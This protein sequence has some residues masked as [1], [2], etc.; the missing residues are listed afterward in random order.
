MKIREISNYLESLAPLSTQES[1]D[2]CGLIYGDPNAAVESALISLDCTE[3]IVQ[4]AIDRNCQLIISHHPIVFKGLRK[5]T[6]ANYVERTMIKAIQNNIAI[7]AIHTNLDNYR[8]GVN[9]KIA[10]KL[11]IS[12]PRILSPKKGELV[13]LVTF[14]PNDHL[15]NVQEA[16]FTAGAGNIGDYEDCSFS[17]VGTGTFK[18]GAATNPHLGKSGKRESTEESRLEVVCSKYAVR[19]VVSSLVQAHPYEEVAYDCYELLNSDSSLGSGM[20]GEFRE[21]IPTLDFLSELKQTFGCGVIRHTALIKDS[22]KTVAWCGGAGSFLLP[23][24]KGKKADIFI[25][26]DYK[27]HEFFDAE[28][29]LIIADIGHFESEQFTIDLIAELLQ[30]K[31]PNFAACLTGV[32]TNPIKY[33]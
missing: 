8:F 1:Y 23:A 13:K 33:F 16:L 24:A 15:L 14:V 30:K 31:F 17:Q 3:D 21:A 25:T 4:E 6:G 12:N 18:G 28:N 9:A 29:Q 32:N 22:I 26:G 20:I 11:K 27:Y 2:N 7:Y 5:L 10:E 19:Q